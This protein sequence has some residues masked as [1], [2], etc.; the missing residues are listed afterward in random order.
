MLQLLHGTYATPL[1][2]E[3][4]GR[5]KLDDPLIVA[6]LLLRIAEKLKA[7]VDEYWRAT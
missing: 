5:V 4:A 1:Y 3:Q 7:C 6:V 2:T